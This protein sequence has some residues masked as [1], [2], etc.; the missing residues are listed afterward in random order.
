MI[1]HYKSYTRRRQASCKDIH[2]SL[3][4]TIRHLVDVLIICQIHENRASLCY[5][6]YILNVARSV[7]SAVV[8]AEHCTPVGGL[9]LLCIL[10]PL[11]LLPVLSLHVRK[12]RRIF[13]QKKSFC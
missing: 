10:T 9:T 11:G 2:V 3:V 6:A 4:G 1:K 8:I 5:G 7:Q 12:L 13:F